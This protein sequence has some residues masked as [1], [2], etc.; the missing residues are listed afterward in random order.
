[1]D[2][3]SLEDIHNPR[4]TQR[5]DIN[6]LTRRKMTGNPEKRIEKLIQNNNTE[7][8]RYLTTQEIKQEIQILTCKTDDIRSTLM[9]YT[10]QQT[11][12]QSQQNRTIVELEDLYQHQIYAM[13]RITSELQRMQEKMEE[14]TQVIKTLS[15]VIG[16]TQK[17]NPPTKDNGQQEL[18]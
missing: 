5:W 7:T 11:T 18:E 12:I 14:Q 15:E 9:K 1:M 13:G 4:I 16:N 2:E 17:T 6:D 3:I 10:D 8:K